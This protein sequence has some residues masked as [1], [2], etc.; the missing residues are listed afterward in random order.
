MDNLLTTTPV[1]DGVFH[2]FMGDK[3]V[4]WIAGNDLAAA[5]ARVLAEGPEKHTGKQYWLSTEVLN[6]AEAAA[7]I[8]Q[9]LQQKV[10]CVVMTPDDLVALIASGALQPPPNIE[11]NYAASMIEMVRQTYDGRLD[12][13]EVTTP[14]VEDLLG[15]KPMTLRTWVARNRN[16]V[17]ETGARAASAA[18]APTTD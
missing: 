1:M 4:G 10:E 13:A 8:A 18:S 17:L 9:A 6:G 12:F 2:W 15:R 16:A 11:A 7:E 14:T 3:G 5:S